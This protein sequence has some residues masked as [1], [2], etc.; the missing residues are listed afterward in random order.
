[1]KPATSK[2]GNSE[3]Y[4]VCLNYKRPEEAVLEGLL[5]FYGKYKY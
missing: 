4:I 1:M 3:V 2:P 5:T